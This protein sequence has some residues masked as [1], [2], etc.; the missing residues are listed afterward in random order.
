MQLSF[1]CQRTYERIMMEVLTNDGLC[2]LDCRDQTVLAE[3]RGRI[4]QVGIRRRSVERV[5]VRR[6]G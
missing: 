2:N 4:G 1:L 3:R 5:D 6:K